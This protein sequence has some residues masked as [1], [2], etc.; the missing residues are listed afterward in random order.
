VTRAEV[1]AMLGLV[2]IPP[3]G[4]PE[5]IA[6][7]YGIH[8]VIEEAVLEAYDAKYRTP[9]AKQKACEVACLIWEAL[10]PEDVRLILG[11]PSPILDSRLVANASKPA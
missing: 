6:R 4:N 1:C 3:S 2:E 8:A 10:A 5:E 11:G 7:W 9:K